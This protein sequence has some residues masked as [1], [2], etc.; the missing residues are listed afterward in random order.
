MALV[1]GIVDAGVAG[2]Q[3]EV[4]DDGVFRF[5]GLEDGHAVDGGSFGAHGRRVDDVAG[6][7][8]QRHVRF[9]EFGVDVL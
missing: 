7:N 1:E 8:D 6:A 9:R 2:L 5:V 3:V 4:A